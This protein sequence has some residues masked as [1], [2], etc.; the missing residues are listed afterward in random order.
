M[1]VRPE[2]AVLVARAAREAGCPDEQLRNFLRAHICFQPAQFRASAAARA[3][4]L[5]DGPTKVGYG[6]ARGGGKSHWGLAQVVCDDCVRRPGLKFLYLRK[7]GKAGREAVNDLRRDVLHSIAHT[8]RRQEGVL[9]LRNGS[10]V[11]LGHFQNEKD[12]DSYLGLQYDGALIEEATQL[13][14]RKVKDISTCIRTS[15]PGWRP[16]TY[17]T[18]NPGNVGHTWFKKLFIEP[19]RRGCETETRFIQAT[20]RDNAFVNGEYRHELE[21]LSGW[22]RRAWLDGDWDIAAGQFYTTFTREEHVC[23]PFQVPRGWRF[24]CAMD[25]GFVHYTCVYL[26]ALDGDGMLYVLDEHAKRGWLPRR[27][28]PAIHAMLRNHRLSVDDL[29]GFVAGADVLQRGKDK[30]GLTIADQ[31][32]ELGISLTAAHD[33]RVNGAAELLSRF[34]DPENGIEPRIWISDSCVRLIECLPALQHDP[35]FPEK[36]KKWDTDD[37]GLGGDDPFDACRYGVMEAPLRVHSWL[38]D[39]PNV[40]DDVGGGMFTRDV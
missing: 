40:D 26:L 6:G 5:P 31:Y 19:L 36:V 17:F 32:Q 25:Y 35:T 23:A 10:A 24:W 38:D 12:I 29:S 30:D 16:R 33:D 20:V 37:D 3:C 8:Y 22:Q 39:L 7:V 21:T 11:V 9:A 2:V 18:T 27:H 28:A 13:T 14:A 1:D 4:D 34:G 15:K